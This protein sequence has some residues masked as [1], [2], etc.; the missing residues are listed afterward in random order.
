MSDIRVH[1]PSMAPVG[2]LVNLQTGLV[3]RR[4]FSDPDIY[5]QELESLFARCR[6]LLAHHSMLPRIGD[7]TTIS[8]GEDPVIVIRDANGRI[9]A[10]LNSCRHRGNR[11]C[12]TPSGN[13]QTFTCM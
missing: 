4:I 11:V 2:D 6:L 10:F 7:Y 3:D 13:T 5:E 12:L 1:T 8:M 9:R